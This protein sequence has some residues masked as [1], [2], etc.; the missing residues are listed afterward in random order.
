MGVSFLIKKEGLENIQKLDTLQINKIASFISNI[1]CQSFPELHLS[2]SD[3]FIQISRLNMYTAKIPDGSSAKYVYGNSEIYFNENLN[4]DTMDIPAIHECIHYIQETKDTKGK[5]IK[6]GLYDLTSETGLAINEAAVQLIATRS[7]IARYENVTYYG[8]SFM[9]ESPEFYPL[10]CALLSQ[11]IYFTGNEPLYFSTLYGNTMFEKEFKNASVGNSYYSILS[12]MDKLLYVENDLNLLS[13]KLLTV[14][15][16]KS[17]LLQFQIENKKKSITNHCLKI[18]NEIIQT[19]LNKRFQE[20]NTFDDIRDFENTMQDFKKMLIIPENYS[21]YEDFCL[22]MQDK[23]RYKKDQIIK[24]GKVLDT[25][26]EYVFE[27]DEKVGNQSNLP[28]ATSMKKLSKFGQ[29]LQALKDII[30]G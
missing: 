3:L 26:K 12:E 27:T 29:I 13:Q 7:K 11:M 30:L 24:F 17:K 19:C 8:M 28:I 15:P 20:I 22:K 18:Q 14:D 10:E 21:F 25:P 16:T 5:L 6:L 1:L 9:T 4:F 2:Q 23:I